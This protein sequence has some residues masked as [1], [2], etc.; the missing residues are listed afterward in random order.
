MPRTSELSKKPQATKARGYKTKK[1]AQRDGSVKL[2][3]RSLDDL[4][5]IR[6]EL[7]E[8]FAWRATSQDDSTLDEKLEAQPGI[9]RAA[10]IK[11]EMWLAESRKDIYWQPATEQPGIR[12]SQ[13]AMYDPCDYDFRDVPFYRS[14]HVVTETPKPVRVDVR[15]YEPDNSSYGRPNKLLDREEYRDRALGLDRLGLRRPYFC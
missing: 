6:Q 1:H 10:E 8:D 5:D 3:R 13:K 15:S 11:R 7:N 9:R 14:N 4:D 12:P 2:R